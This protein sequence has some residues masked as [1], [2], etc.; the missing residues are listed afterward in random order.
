[1]NGVATL[2]NEN[3]SFFYIFDERFVRN[4]GKFESHH[5]LFVCVNS[6]YIQQT[7]NCTMSLWQHIN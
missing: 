1:M 4:E 3:K 5:A 2:K 7:I 6:K